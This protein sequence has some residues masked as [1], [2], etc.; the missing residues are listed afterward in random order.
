M[1][2]AELVLRSAYRA[3][4]ARDVEAALE[5]MH[6]EVDW[7][8]AWEGGRVIGRAAVRDYWNRQ[9]AAISSNVEPQ[10]FIEQSDGNIVV[11]VHQ[12]VRD[13]HTGDLLSDSSIRHCYRLQDGMIAR[14][15]V[16]ESGT[17][18]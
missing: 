17:H 2:E 14:M 18:S 8:N 9:F 5:L 3:F 6:P 1:P 13:A 16:L 15:D 4:N 11:D 10:R 12:V 7:P